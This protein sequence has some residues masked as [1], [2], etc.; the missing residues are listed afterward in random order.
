MNPITSAVSLIKAAVRGASEDKVPMMGA[1]LAYYTAFSIAPLL[2][3]AIG[4]VGIVF[5]ASGGEGVFETVRGLVGEKA[6]H[7]VR[8]MVEGASSRPRAGVVATAIGLATL[9]LGASGV[10]GQLQ[11]ALNVIWKAKLRPD[12]GWGLTLRRRLLSFGMVGVI[13]FLLLASLIVSAGIAAAGKLFIGI[14]PGGEAVWQA[15]NLAVSL[16]VTSVLF[17]MIYKALPDVRL[18]WRDALIGGFFTSVLFSLGQFAI[19]LYLGKS[20]V[21]SAYGAAGSVIVLLLWVYYS[22][23]IVLFGAEL[24]RAYVE[25]SG[26]P[27]ALKENAVPTLSAVDAAGTAEKRVRNGKPAAVWYVLG[28]AALLGG[29]RLIRRGAGQGWRHPWRHGVLGGVSAGAGLALLAL[30]KERRLLEPDGGEG[31]EKGPSFSRRVIARIPF[32]VKKAAVVGALKGAGAEAMR[33][34]LEKVSK[35]G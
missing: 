16:G 17:A 4:V 15:V 21:A 10:F 20:G 27:L 13:A 23:Q 34:A 2:V 25:R 24:T 33:E 12:A 22:S 14:L 11:E 18:P 9:I 35:R 26:R 30:L 1:A 7:A 5:G 19:G 32:K 8:L 29:A 31:E 6:A 28:S 3:I